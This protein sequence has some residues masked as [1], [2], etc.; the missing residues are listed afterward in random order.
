MKY[1]NLWYLRFY[2]IL[3]RD[4]RCK[5]SKKELWKISFVKFLYLLG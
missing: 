3:E 1:G 5:I 4:M 2:A